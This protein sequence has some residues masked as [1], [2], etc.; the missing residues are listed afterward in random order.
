MAIWCYEGY[1]IISN[2]PGSDFGMR[3]SINTLTQE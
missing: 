1:L 3:A 2:S